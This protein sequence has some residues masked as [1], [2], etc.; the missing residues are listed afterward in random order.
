M[1]RAPLPARI[2]SDLRLLGLTMPLRPSLPL[3]TSPLSIYAS[4]PLAPATSPALL[5]V[6]LYAARALPPSC[7]LTS[8]ASSSASLAASAPATASST[9]TAAP[10]AATSSAP[11][12]S[13]PPPPPPRT[14]VPA[15]AKAQAPRDVPT[16]AEVAD[17]PLPRSNSSRSTV[18]STASPAM[19][20][21]MQDEDED[22]TPAMPDAR[23]VIAMALEVQK[24]KKIAAAAAAATASAGAAMGPERIDEWHPLILPTSATRGEGPPLS[25]LFN[26]LRTRSGSIHWRAV[27]QRD[28][29]SGEGE[30][31]GERTEA[32]AEYGRQG[33]GTQG[34][35]RH[36]TK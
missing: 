25:Y 20:K 29:C 26:P 15:A 23:A 19:E 6:P 30:E 12:S 9:T 16:V 5:Q 32:Q 27:R 2:L 7:S 34:S 11:N 36:I 33:R 21:A 22:V 8:L 17:K 10:A 28:A 31:E 18:G 4:F 13:I 35:A 3:P 24:R 1:K 14:H